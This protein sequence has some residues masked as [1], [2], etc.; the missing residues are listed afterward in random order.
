M[1]FNEFQEQFFHKTS[2]EDYFLKLH[3]Q[4]IL[5]AKRRGQEESDSIRIC[6]NV[7]QSEKH[8]QM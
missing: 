2:P 4:F 5:A 1:N 6:I 7:N 3:F 8:H